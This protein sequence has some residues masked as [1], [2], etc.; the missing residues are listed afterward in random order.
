MLEAYIN[1]FSYY[2]EEKITLFINVDISK[3]VSIK[4]IDKNLK[5]FYNNKII[6]YLRF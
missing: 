3:N 1:E 2:K 4:I 6:Y 5:I